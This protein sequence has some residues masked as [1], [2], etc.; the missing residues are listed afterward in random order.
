[1][2]LMLCVLTTHTIYDG[3]LFFELNG[4]AV[5]RLTR[6]AA[7]PACRLATDRGLHGMGGINIYTH[8]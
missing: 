8:Y 4:N 2:E 7:M 6:M 3:G 1:M 5:M